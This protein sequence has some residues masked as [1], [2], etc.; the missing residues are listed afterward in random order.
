MR[1]ETRERQ[2]KTVH[3]S[4]LASA[5]HRKIGER[6]QALL[7]FALVAPLLCLVSV[8]IV[9]IGRAARMSIVLT[10]AATAGVQFGAQSSSNAD[11][12]TGIQNAA[13]CDANGGNWGACSSG[14]L[15]VANIAVIHGCRC[16]DGTGLS[17]GPTMPANG[18]CAAIS[19]GSES[20]VECIQVTTHADFAPLFQ[21]PGLPSSYQSN[22]NSVM[23][24]RQ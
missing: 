17:C 11:N 10:N 24:V 19:C 9:E 18:T 23:R 8:G 21:W 2:K 3:G 20:I 5:R 6:G 1:Q 16:D 15:S 13:L 7:E 4:V 14:I 22:G 12:T